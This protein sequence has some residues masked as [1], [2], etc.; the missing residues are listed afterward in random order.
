MLGRSVQDVIS[1]FQL[2]NVTSEIWAV[3][4]AVTEMFDKRVGLT[5]LAY[6][7]TR[8]QMRSATE[9]QV[10]SEQIS[11]RPDDMAE[12]LENSM[13]ILA[14]REA[15]ACRWLLRG[16][17]VAPVLGPVGALAWEQHIASIEPGQVAREFDYRVEAG[18]ARKPNKATRQ[19]Q[20]QMALQTLGPVLQQMIPMG[21]V[22]PFNALITDWADSLDLNAEPY[23]VPPPPPPPEQPAMDEPAPDAPP[24]EGATPQPPQEL[25]P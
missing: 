5:E 15:M 25:A 19:E 7:M 18:S 22:E 20:M 24:P 17:D 4:Q 8:A 2:P 13:S 3:I 12:V 16:Q 23:L 9:A 1:V 21:V 11:V 14:R 6:G 10:R